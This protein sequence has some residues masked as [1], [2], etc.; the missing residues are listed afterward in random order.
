MHDYL[1]YHPNIVRLLGFEWGPSV[2]YDAAYPVLILEHA[3]YGSLAALQSSVAPL[4]FAVKQKLCH[5]V[6]R[7]LSIL[8]AC[9]I[10]HGDVKSENVLIFKNRYQEPPGQ[11]YTAKL[12]DFGAA[13]MD[14]VETKSYR[15]RMGT[16]PFEAP[17]ASN[18]LSPTS[19][20]KTD[21]YSFGML[22]W[23]TFID[24]K[25]VLA[26][27][28]LS[29]LPS[30]QVHTQVKQL[31][32]TDALF[33][34]AT[35][36]VVRYFL[37]Y[38]DRRKGLL[39]AIYPLKVCIAVDPHNRSLAKAQAALRGMDLQHLKRYLSEMDTRNSAIAQNEKQK[40]PGSHGINV[41]GIGFHL[42]RIAGDDY[43]AQV[44]LPGH[45]TT[46]PHPVKAE[47]LF[48]P[49]KLKCLLSWQQQG[50]IVRELEESTKPNDKTNGVT[51][52]PFEAAYYLF[53][54]YLNEFGVQF[55]A[56]KACEWLFTCSNEDDMA[57]FNYYAQAWAWRVGDA[58][59]FPPPFE[60]DKLRDFICIGICRGHRLCIGDIQQISRNLASP[61]E[62]TIWDEKLLLA[63][64]NLR[65]LSGGTGM[66]YHVP[67]GLYHQFN[68]HDIQ[69]LEGEIRSVLGADFD[70]C[71]R[72]KQ[73]HQ[74]QNPEKSAFDK[75]YLTRAGS[76][77]LHHA[78]TMGN[79]EALEYMTRTYV[80]NID[81]ENQSLYETPLVSACR[82]GQYECATFLIEAGAR[83]TASD[84]GEEAPLH[85]LLGF[86]DNEMEPMGRKLIAAGADLEQVCGNGNR[87]IKADWEKCFQVLVTPLG[88]AVLMCNIKAVK[89]LL[90][91][92]ADP[93]GKK[94]KG[95]TNLIS[96]SPIE[97][98]AILT[99]P[100]ILQALLSHL[101]D[102]QA[103][104]QDVFDELEMLEAARKGEI[105]KFDSL[106]LQSTLVRCG[107]KYQDALIQTMQILRE[108]R[109]SLHPEDGYVSESRVAR[110][111]CS[112]ITLGNNDI[113]E[114][115]LNLG[116]SV[117]GTDEFRPLRYAVLTNNDGIFQIFVNNGADV[118]QSVAGDDES[119]LHLLASRPPTSR[120]GI[121]IAERLLRAGIP[122]EKSSDGSP[123]PFFL[124]VENHHFDLADL[125]LSNGA[126][127]NAA[128]KSRTTDIRVTILGAMVASQ[129]QRSLRS[130]GFLSE[131]SY[132]RREDS[133]KNILT[134]KNNKP[135]ELSDVAMLE[136]LMQRLETPSQDIAAIVDP[137]TKLN[138]LHFLSI[139]GSSSSVSELISHTV[140]S[141]FG[142]QKHINYV[143]PVVGTPL[144]LAALMGNATILNR[145]LDRDADRT[146]VAHPD[147]CYDD[148]RERGQLS[149]PPRSGEPIWLALCQLNSRL[150]MLVGSQNNSNSGD[151]EDVVRDRLLPMY[152][153]PKVS[154]AWNAYLDRKDMT[155]RDREQQ[156][157][158][159]S[160]EAGPAVQDLEMVPIDLSVLSE[161]KESGWQ[162]GCEMTSE[163]AS[164]TFLKYLRGKDR[165]SRY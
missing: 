135:G 148:Y 16:F 53:Q 126:D 8:H 61:E 117:S 43:D 36:S 7:G 71:L 96:Q 78:A 155:Q 150:D 89:V 93:L 88:R 11:P 101:D 106:S 137:D 66:G 22:V 127:I 42:G 116:Y 161:E 164:R 40:T 162:D 29:S 30:S 23:R 121:G 131:R 70:A 115:I 129:N 151:F 20:K 109:L 28:G 27:L 149:H 165:Y 95:T 18:S 133:I 136:T 138:V 39:V 45:R 34:K 24:G 152:E 52:K 25:D 111:L 38:R 139:H 19:L 41:D 158:A 15:L 91:L 63:K 47:F 26:E 92:G 90:K 81:L 3:T 128:Y 112:E 37:S 75:I 77:L 160:V 143:H 104:K 51:I 31:K 76:G 9:G 84:I 105:L 17:E 125:L 159:D 44:N 123:S 142:Q 6:A 108:R 154:E 124:A 83:V 50:Q 94:Q 5:D 54:C 14:F 48:E 132:L 153:N 99:L 21:V 87:H 120:P 118:H 72:S 32:L 65:T 35:E 102:T 4:S 62:R 13:S 85:W 1:R 163:M 141:L 134:E 97:V 130:I 67:R 68:L 64:L 146:L 2:D 119:L 147:L 157:Q 69:K 55:D 107:S 110:Q 79:L 56:K 103:E 122:V 74:D 156:K 12:A 58:L 10:I 144:C 82:S 49:W 80:C 113:V 46:L 33:L 86:E 57:G 98:A 60:E 145:L 59:G 100:A 114:A 73:G 140:L